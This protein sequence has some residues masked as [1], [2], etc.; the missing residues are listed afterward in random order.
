LNQVG[1]AGLLL[2]RIDYLFSKDNK[3]K[4]IACN[5]LPIDGNLA[6]A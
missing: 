1:W 2:G 3:I 4:A 5:T 6:K